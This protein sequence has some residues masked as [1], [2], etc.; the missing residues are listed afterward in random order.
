MDYVH[1]QLCYIV[2]KN[3]NYVISHC[4]L[5]IKNTK[6]LRRRTFVIEIDSSKQ[7]SQLKTAIKKARQ[8]VST[9]VD[10]IDIDLWKVQISYES[11]SELANPSLQEKLL[12]PEDISSQPV[13]GF[14][15]VIVE[16]TEISNDREHQDFEWEEAWI[17]KRE[18][19]II[20]NGAIF[21]ITA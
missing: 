14:I 20:R 2:S 9:S 13:E 8:A 12:A 18:A 17:I 16:G 19:Q 7:V 6:C 11:F 15:N 5:I 21:E 3:F 10:V 1:C 4:M